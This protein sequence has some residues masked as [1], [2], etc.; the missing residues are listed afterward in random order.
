VR[1]LKNIFPGSRSANS[2]VSLRVLSEIGKSFERLQSEDFRRTAVSYPGRRDLVQLSCV[3]F[4]SW[5]VEECFALIPLERSENFGVK[6]KR[7]TRLAV[8]ARHEGL[9]TWRALQV[10]E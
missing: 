1:G 7:G 3:D 5:T 2:I 4:M 10:C 9:L 8:S 6:E